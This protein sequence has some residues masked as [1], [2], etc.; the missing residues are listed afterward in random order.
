[1]RKGLYQCPACLWWWCWWVRRPG[2]LEL[3]RT[4]RKCAHR[5]RAQLKRDANGRTRG[6]VMLHRPQEMP[7]KALRIE[8]RNRNRR[9][10]DQHDQALTRIKNKQL[11]QRSLFHD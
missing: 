4:C 3:S 7:D 10:R 11:E 1:M 8:C 5:V 9:I 6:W 2:T